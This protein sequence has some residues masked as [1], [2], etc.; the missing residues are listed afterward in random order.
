MWV[1]L[2]VK[3]FLQ[4]PLVPVVKVKVKYYDSFNNIYVK[5]IDLYIDITKFN[6]NQESEFDFEVNFVINS[7]NRIAEREVN[8]DN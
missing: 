1:F 5:D 6:Y 4:E 2:D 8:D 7:L 3:K